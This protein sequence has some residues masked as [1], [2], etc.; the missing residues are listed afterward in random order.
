M[1]GQLNEYYFKML[2]PSICKTIILFLTMGALLSAPIYSAKSSE[3][4]STT[5]IERAQSESPAQK[6]SLK[7]LRQAQQEASK[8]LKVSGSSTTP[9]LWIRTKRWIAQKQAEISRTFS[10]YIDRFQQTNDA[11]FAF[12]LI[13]ASLAY[14]LVHAAGPGHGKVVVSSYVMAN[15]QTMRRGI[16]LAFLSSF[17]QGT[18]AIVLVGAMAYLFNATGASIK[19]FGLKLTQLSYIFII[20]LGLYL[21][22]SVAYRRFK[23]A[24]SVKTAHSH[25]P[26]CAHTHTHDYDHGHHDH[27]HHG[28]EACGCG[29]MHIPTSDQV[30]GSWNIAKITSL[31]LSV[32]LRPCTGALY[33]L[34]F[35][36]IKNLFW[37]GAIA[38]YAMALGTAVTISLMTMAVVGGR[39]LA[40]VSTAGNHRGVRLVYDLCAF[41]GAIMIILF[42][43]L[44]LAGSLGPV[45][46]F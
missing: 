15:N 31:V 5:Q 25:S 12:A 6:K 1:F 23:T 7:A 41:G 44:L 43:S 45:S 9:N 40:L 33:V 14:G 30:Q 29:H 24:T 19:Q 27:L 42:G 8:K 22:A 16:I 37:V 36:L 17:V 20:M 39:E 18:V 38:V 11:R 10:H 34:A 21:L 26:S 13:L 3:I 2:N 32:G 4:K 28:E 46:P 35:A